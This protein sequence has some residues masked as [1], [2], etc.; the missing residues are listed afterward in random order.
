MDRALRRLEAMM[1]VVDTKHTL[2]VSGTGDVIQ[3]N[4]GIVAIG[5]GGNYAMAA[6]RALARHSSLTA[7]EI[8]TE[9]LTVASEIDIYTN[10]NIVCETLESSEA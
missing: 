2:L 9:A 8:V 1:T 6:A 4:D 5:S 7:S 3:P 10:S